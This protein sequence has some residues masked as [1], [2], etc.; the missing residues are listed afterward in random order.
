MDRET[1]LDSVPTTDDD[2]ALELAHVHLPLLEDHGLVEYDARTETIRYYEC[3]LVSS[4]LGLI[5][6]TTV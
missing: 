5:E 1:L 6:Q 4:V 2:W 3:E